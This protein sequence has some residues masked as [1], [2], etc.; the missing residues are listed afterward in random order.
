[1]T[2][3]ALGR[4]LRWTLTPSMGLAL[5]T[6]SEYGTIV[7][8]SIIPYTSNIFKKLHFVKIVIFL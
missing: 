1:M 6:G 4:G 8:Q 3:L 7:F 2:S 5:L